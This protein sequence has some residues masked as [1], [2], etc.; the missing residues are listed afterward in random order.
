MKKFRL[1]IE[2][3]PCIA[4]IHG[5][6]SSGLL[7]KWNCE[8]YLFIFHSAFSANSFSSSSSSSSIT[9][10]CKHNVETYKLK[11]K[12]ARA[13]Y[14]HIISSTFQKFSVE[15]MVTL[16]TLH[17]KTIWACVS[18]W[19]NCNELADKPPPRPRTETEFVQNSRCCCTCFEKRVHFSFYSVSNAWNSECLSIPDSNSFCASVVVYASFILHPANCIDMTRVEIRWEHD[20]IPWSLLVKSCFVLAVS[21]RIYTFERWALICYYYDDTFQDYFYLL[22]V[23]SI[24]RC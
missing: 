12:R 16:F 5:Q 22:I 2:L 3:Q 15:K 1:K 13:F 21:H 24:D 8:C 9:N 14:F 11:Q 23:I 17:V 6:S 7:F 20:A 19:V 10:M 18:V 4:A